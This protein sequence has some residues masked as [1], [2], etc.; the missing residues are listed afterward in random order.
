[1]MLIYAAAIVLYSPGIMMKYIY[2]I[3]AGRI[4]VISLGAVLLATMMYATDVLKNIILNINYN[5]KIK[6]II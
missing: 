2:V 5:I 1:M 4:R 6:S 3:Y